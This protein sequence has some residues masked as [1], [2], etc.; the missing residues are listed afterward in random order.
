MSNKP[1]YKELEKENKRLREKLNSETKDNRFNSYFDNNHAVMMQIDV[2]T[3]QI[4]KANKAAVNFYKYPE[5]ELLKKT[6][7]D[8][9]LLSASEI[10]KK[11]NETVKNKSALF[12]FQHKTAEGEIKDVEVYAS[13]F[14][15]G[16]KTFIYVI[17]HDISERKKTEKRL[18]K[19]ETYFKSLTE[20]SSD[21]ISVID[22]NG[23]SLYRSPSYEKVMGFSAEEML[24]KNVF[25]FIH[26]DDKENLRK[27]I[28]ES[29]SKPNQ[30]KKISF[31]ALHK[32][33]TY[34]YLEGTGKNLLDTP[35]NGI[36]INYRDITQ[37]YTSQEALKESEKKYQKL[38]DNSTI[39]VLIADIKDMKFI[40][41]NPAICEMF[42]YSE[43]EFT[44]LSVNNIHPKDALEFVVSE[45]NAQAKKE[46]V[47]ATN[48]PCL[49]KDGTVFYANINTTTNLIDGIE[50]NVGFFNDIT[51]QKENATKLKI[52]NEEYASLNEEY[53]SLNEEL[54]EKNKE[55]FALNEEYKSQN[56]D[57]KKAKEIAEESEQRFKDLTNLLPQIIYECDIEGNLTYVNEQAF[58]F[59]RYTREDFEKGINL[60]QALIP[61]DREKAK[62]DFQKVL[63]GEEPENRN[64]TALRKD[65]TTFP[66][67]IF[68]SVTLKN[69]KPVGLRGVIIDITDLKK[70]QE[71][72][73]KAKEKAEES[74][75]LKTEFINNMSH[76]IRTP[77]NGILGFS[78]L[79]STPDLPPEKL[80]NYISII[81]NSG[82]QLMRIIDDILEISKLGTKQVKAIENKVYLNDL[83]LELFSIFDIRAKENKTPLY[84]KKGLPDTESMVLTDSSKL[85][86]ILS[87]LLENA[88]KFTNKG[89]I[90]FG[91][92][93]KNDTIMIYVKDTGIGIK[94]EKQE[95]IFERFS[96]EEKKVS[97]HAGGLGLGLSIAKENAELLGGTI[98]LESEKGKGSTFYITIPYKPFEDNHI[99]KTKK[100]TMT[101]KKTQTILIAEDEE[102]NFIYIETLLEYFVKDLIVLHAIDG[103]Q[104]VELCKERSDIDFV[105][106][107]LKMPV[108][109]GYEATKLIK[110]F[111]PDLPV[112]AQ[113]AYST[114][115]EK[116]KALKAGC[117][118]FISKPISKEIFSKVID[119]YKTK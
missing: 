19:S 32:D 72:T 90:E 63:Q 114:P 2:E 25:N 12:E 88:L 10:Q 117:D 82:K 60:M 70:A 44:K 95:T 59:F 40:S 118:D 16:T 9:Y 99:I 119:K 77:M 81:Q 78:E 83:F 79:L 35:I 20:N 3:K 103:K 101:D 26:P 107:D 62:T 116:E 67:L 22:K 69:K 73:L 61:E 84:L 31:K 11:I 37:E 108:M 98:T 30:V 51:E 115:E 80:I 113:T 15:N 50:C 66:V 47:L 93:V 36:V 27:Q 48:I 4:I 45:F 18:L 21:V 97:E 7:N 92:R 110:E 86:K 68:S 38:F 85:N 71:E 34:H 91:Y 14:K 41:A 58:E 111:R 23:K 106:M 102:V 5:E 17:I 53:L 55:Y 75:R 65:G 1:T 96:Q 94:P 28:Q 89:F 39:G 100:K 104:A 29:L 76:E 49:R 105:L 6:V 109:D 46:K 56:E 13:P 8:L 43:K 112:I 52:Q 54:T 74:D 24:S 57:L 87:N 42:G 33:G 64:F